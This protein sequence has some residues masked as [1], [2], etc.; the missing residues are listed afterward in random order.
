MAVPVRYS[1]L[2][3]RVKRRLRVASCRLHLDR[4][5]SLSWLD[6]RLCRRVAHA[7]TSLIL[8]GNLSRRS[9][10]SVRVRIQARVVR[11]IMQLGESF[12]PLH[13]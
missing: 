11:T 7:E 10:A 12:S 2:S 1:E 4:N 13:L 6:G 3:V 5:F 8:M 9:L